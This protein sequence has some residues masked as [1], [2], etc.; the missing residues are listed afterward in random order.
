MFIYFSFT[1][2]G[3]NL[4]NMCHDTNR[5]TKQLSVIPRCEQLGTLVFLSCCLSSTQW[6]ML[7]GHEGERQ[8]LLGSLSSGLRPAWCGWL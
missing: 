6:E 3:N 7:S 8:C 5:R 2:Y 4:Q 1:K